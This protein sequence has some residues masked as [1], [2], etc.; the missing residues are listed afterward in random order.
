ML[1]LFKNKIVYFVLVTSLFSLWLVGAYAMAPVEP[2]V[3]ET[4]SAFRSYKKIEV[5]DILVPTVVEI[6]FDDQYLERANFAVLDLNNNTFQPYYYKKEVNSNK[7]YYSATSLPYNSAARKMTDGD[8]NTYA[9]FEYQENTQNEL[10]ILLNSATPIT[11]SALTLVLDRFVALPHT[12]QIKATVNNRE[13]VILATTNMVSQNIHFPVT[14]AKDWEINL[15]YGQPL[16]ISEINLVQ[17]NL[18]TT[19]QRTVRFL[20]QPEHF[21][22]VYYDPDRNV[23]ISTGEAGNLSSNEDVLFLSDNMTLLNPSYKIADSDLDGH[24]DIIDN[25]IYDYNPDQKDV[26]NNGRGDV[27]E[28]FDKDGIMND[29]DNCPNNPNRY[30][31]DQDKDGIGDACDNEES[32]LTEKYKWIPWAGIVFALL[33]IIIL[34]FVT[35]RT[36]PENHNQN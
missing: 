16:R 27:C 28:D 7:T 26:N 12:I 21:Y 5:G 33:V 31:T 15:T 9:E 10:N 29:K 4:V 35:A 24:A 30:Q 1:S 22:E 18:I 14:T 20:A 6:P 25:C 13:K 11:S 32:R 34:F 2:S 17:S 36:K 3:A 8:P 19:S 23:T